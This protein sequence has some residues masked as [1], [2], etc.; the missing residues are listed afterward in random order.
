MITA[1]GKAKIFDFEKQSVLH[2]FK[3]SKDYEETKQIYSLFSP[4]FEIPAQEFVDEELLIREKYIAPNSNIYRSEKLHNN[5]LKDYYERFNDYLRNCSSTEKFN[6]CS[7]RVLLE[8]MSQSLLNSGLG[9]NVLQLLF[10]SETN[11][12]LQ[13]MC[14]GDLWF[15]NILIGG[16]FYIIDW[17]HA[18]EYLF[19]YDFFHYAI[20][21]YMRK[22]DASI[23][24][25]YF[26]G[27][28]DYIFNELFEI[29]G[30]TYRDEE[31]LLYFGLSVLQKATNLN[32]LGM[33]DQV[34]RWLEFAEHLIAK[35]S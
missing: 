7:P 22:G 6:V 11:E 35:Y 25:R 31:R 15:E 28:F 4:F 24:H 29:V 33:I 19:F 34:A 27:Q 16:T 13:V 2:F 32:R 9:Q 12:W 17:E 20:T 30:L 1:G 3:E 5:I 23:V 21:E 10:D 8:S 14:H 26:M 18:G